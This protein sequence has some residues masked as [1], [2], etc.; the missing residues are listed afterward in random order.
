MHKFERY[1]DIPVLI[2]MCM[3]TFDSKTTWKAAYAANG[4][5]G[6]IGAPLSA[7]G[8][9]GSLLLVI[10]ALSVV[11]NNV[12]NM[13]SFSLSFQVFGKYAQAIPRMYAK[14]SFPSDFTE[15]DLLNIFS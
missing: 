15:P 10:L 14:S 11:A 5:G 13:Y 2:I 3:A 4:V 9:F 8:K 1:A 6:L 7:M 12:P